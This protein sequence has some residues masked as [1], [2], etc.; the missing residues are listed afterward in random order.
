MMIKRG[1]C[2]TICNEAQSPL[3]ASIRPPDRTS[4]PISTSSPTQASEK[5]GLGQYVH[6]LLTPYTSDSRYGG[7][8][9]GGGEGEGGG[10][11]G[12][13]GEGGG[14]GGGG[15]GGGG[16]GEGGGG[17]GGGKGGGG[18]GEGGGGE[19]GGG[20]SGGPCDWSCLPVTEIEGTGGDF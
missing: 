8:E 14:E 2:R 15:E 19:G 3:M 10:G 18:E 9:G 4:M 17:E 7:G 12:G 1:A 11:E 6:P 13:G 20:E 5:G 16:E